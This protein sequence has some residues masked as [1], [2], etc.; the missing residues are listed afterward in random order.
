MLGGMRQYPYTKGVSTI[1]PRIVC[2]DGVS[3]SVQGHLGS[4]S[5][6]RDDFAE[7]Y[8]QVEVGFFEDAKGE[9]LTPPESWREYADG[10][11]PSSVYGYVPLRLVE[12]FI[13]EHGGIKA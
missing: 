12:D 4:Y 9:A 10:D 1:F 5:R 6:P 13:A 11:F 3:L 2:V 7:I 8:L